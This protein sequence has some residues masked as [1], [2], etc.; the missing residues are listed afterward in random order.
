MDHFC[1]TGIHLVKYLLCNMKS[2]SV[3]CFSSKLYISSWIYIYTLYLTIS[4]QLIYRGCLLLHGNWSQLLIS[5]VRVAQCSLS[6]MHVLDVS[7]H[8][9]FGIF[10]FYISLQV[11]YHRSSWS[12]FI[13]FSFKNIFTNWYSITSFLLFTQFHHQLT[14]LCGKMSYFFRDAIPVLWINQNDR[15]KLKA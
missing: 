6:C 5:E 13:I 8:F 10:D 9:R 12:H 3:Y 15:S 11:L 4:W 2:A 1:V 14:R 7:D